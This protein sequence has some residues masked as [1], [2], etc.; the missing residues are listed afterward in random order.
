[1]IESHLFLS[2]ALILLGCF[3]GLSTTIGILRFPDLYTRIHAGAVALTMSALLITIGAA[4]YVWEPILSGK[5]L[6]IGVFLLISN[7]MATHA[8]ARVAYRQ[9]IA[10]PIIRSKLPHHTPEPGNHDDSS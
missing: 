1:M 5:I 10:I 4:V 6:L 2:Y 9:R 8:I 3:F 7:P